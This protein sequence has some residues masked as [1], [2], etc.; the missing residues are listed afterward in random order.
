MKNPVFGRSLEPK[1]AKNRGPSPITRYYSALEII[2]RLIGAQPLTV[3]CSAL[4]GSVVARYLVCCDPHADGRGFRS[5]S[6]TLDFLAP[7]QFSAFIVSSAERVREKAADDL[8][9][10]LSHV[11]PSEAREK[12][13]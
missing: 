10:P 8:L 13:D 1:V 9:K 11:V 5:C 7:N 12:S 3:S 2:S 6:R 4:L